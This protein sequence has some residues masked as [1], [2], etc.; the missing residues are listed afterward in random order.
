MWMETTVKLVQLA[1][2][3]VCADGWVVVDLLEVHVYATQL[4]LVGLS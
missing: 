2:H 3:V 1:L 4:A